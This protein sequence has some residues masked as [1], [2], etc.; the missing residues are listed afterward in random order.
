MSMKEEHEEKLF[1]DFPELFFEERRGPRKH[2]MISNIACGDGWFDIIYNLCKEIHPMRATIMQIKE[3]F[4]TLRF[5]CSFP[6]DYS[7]RGYKFI[8]EAEEKSGETC[9]TCGDPAEFRVR[10]G[11]R[12]VSCQP[13]HEKY[14]E[15]H[16]E[17]P[18]P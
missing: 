1:N 11:W 6:E 16:P 2:T 10:N 15:E 17:E 8:R 7:E 9:E 18:Y 13:C 3:K 4:G 12:Y 14:C 5:Y